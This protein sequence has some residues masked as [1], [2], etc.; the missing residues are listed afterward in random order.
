MK[1]SFF[2]IIAA[3]ALVLL[4]GSVFAR[5]ASLNGAGIWSSVDEKRMV[6][7]RPPAKQNAALRN[8]TPLVYRT[9]SLSRPALE[10]LLA[11]APQEFAVPMAMSGVELQIPMPSGEYARFRIEA[12]P[13]MESALA[14]KF[15][16]IKTYIGQG[17][18]D[19]T[20]TMRGDL[21]PRG[22]HAII[23]SPKGDVYVD[24]YWRDSDE[25]YV[26][27]FKHD[28]I[29]PEKPFSCL[30]GGNDQQ[31]ALISR[32]TPARPTGAM[33][34]SY[35][36]AVP[37]TG[38]YATYVSQPNSPTVAAALAAIITTVNRCS[39]VYE[40]EF[41][42]RFVLVANE[43]QVVYLN[44]NTDPFT[45]SSPN[46]LLSQN[47][48]TCDNVI[49]SANYD[50]GHVFSTAG[51]G[52]S[53]LGVV[54]RNGQK[55]ESETGTSAPRGDPF[56]IDYVV[57]EMGHEFGANHP[58][59]GTSGSCSGG[60]RN[61]P[62]AY[63]VG[64]GTTIMAYAGICAPQDLAPHSDDYF[65]TINYD[66]IDNY[67]ANGNG[68][69]CPAMT[70]TG[71]TPPT[72]GAL[73][74]F[75]IPSQTPFAL[76][77]SATDPDGDTLTYCWEE[78]D[79]GPAQDPTAN[80][81]DNGSSP[82]F[83]SFPPTT[84]PTRLFPSLTYILHN[85]NVPPATLAA[86]LISGEFLPTTS[87]TMTY[88]VTVR[89]NR[90]GGGGSNYASTT[91]TS[92]S[93][94]GPFAI[95]A[96]NSAMTIAGGSQQTVTWNVAGSNAAPIN[97]SNVK[98]TLSTDGGH[99]FPIVLAA[100]V[101]N[102][103]SASVV[104]PNDP[105]VATNQGRIKVEAVGNIFFDISDADLTITSSSNTPPTLSITAGITVMRGTPTPTV[106][107]VGTAN[108]AEGNPLTVSVTDVPFGAHLTPTISNGTIS[109]GALVDCPLVTT[110]TSR[111]YPV[112]LIVTDSNGASV[113]GV[114]N[115]I[116]QPNPSPTLGT[117][118]DLTVPLGTRA[119]S[120]PSAPAAD[121]N[122]NLA[123]TPY[124]VTPTSLP[125]GGFVTIDQRTGAVTVAATSANRRLTIPGTYPITVTVLDT[126][127]A[128]AV[129]I[130]NA[131]VTRTQ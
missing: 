18:D 67:T 116:V 124:S 52:L 43:D 30:V 105:S 85:Q 121:A 88:R 56:D 49:G 19:P 114:V 59:N 81:R 17:I 51:G 3:A 34:R 122:N 14:A 41:A 7:A 31:S 44:P 107:D 40:R 108:D 55:A 9:V 97:C 113:S 72:I 96:P 2:K 76:T 61:G 10:R 118:P 58:F 8:I 37:C 54:C 73:T 120:T 66:E 25:T 90:A 11:G 82:I 115:L 95:T 89:D 128:A 111:T 29:A 16:N 48:T 50:F 119:R 75:S 22:F 83:R 35:R 62:T 68:R 84:N 1:S 32:P 21:T 126:C 13:I 71:N 45:N 27:Y 28:F 39:A 6:A 102:I 64:S 24:P 36:L 33:L 69:T 77:A 47:Q 100:S 42:I 129:Q 80:P 131:T 60:N 104:V 57:H 103:G 5:S 98:I 127:G 78:F 110:L 130:F 20:A 70:A 63:E 79:R 125:G 53:A 101:P 94:A 86:D 123:A 46:A 87:R 112:T 4:I 15:P 12:S 109:I 23:L 38:E 99:T 92:V 26:S 65:Y 93:T 91:V 74:P 106:A 117:Y